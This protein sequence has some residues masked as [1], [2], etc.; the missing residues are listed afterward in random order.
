MQRSIQESSTS[1]IICSVASKSQMFEH[2]QIV[3]TITRYLQTKKSV[4]PPYNPYT[5]LTTYM[6][7]SPSTS[8]RSVHAIVTPSHPITID[9]DILRAAI[10]VLEKNPHKVDQECLICLVTD[11]DGADHHF[12]HCPILNNHEFLKTAYIK[13]TLEARPAIKA[14]AAALQKKTAINSIA[15]M[16]ESSMPSES[17]DQAS[18]EFALNQIMSTID[19]G[20]NEEEEQDFY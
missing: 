13:A 3:S 15:S 12:G 4:S 19:E 5:N 1:A 11:P 16:S 17:S 20:A 2:D 6:K 18:K 14:Q 8:N 10:N 7:R 9:M